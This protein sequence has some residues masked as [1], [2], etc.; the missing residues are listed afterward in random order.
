MFVQDGV[1]LTVIGI[2][3]GLLA[4]AATTRLMKAILF[5]ISPLDGPTYGVV[6]LVFLMVAI[7]ASYVPA[8]RATRIDPLEALKAE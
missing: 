6:P 4:S 2:A 5:G 3:I 8:A 1:R 7:V